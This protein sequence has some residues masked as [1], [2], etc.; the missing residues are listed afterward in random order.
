[1]GITAGHT[2]VQQRLWGI[3]AVTIMGIAIILICI[4]LQRSLLESLVETK[5][6]PRAYPLAKSVVDALEERLDIHPQTSLISAGRPSS[7]LAPSDVVL[8]IGAVGELDPKLADELAD[9]VR[10]KMDD[11]TLAVEVHCVQELWLKNPP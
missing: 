3:R 7:R 1:M 10:Q 9:I 8:V 2:D 11:P 5:P 4:P 6:Q